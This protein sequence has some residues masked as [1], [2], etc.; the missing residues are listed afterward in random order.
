[1]VSSESFWVFP[2]DAVTTK[3]TSSF[4][5]KKEMLCGKKKS[6]VKNAQMLCI[7]VNICFGWQHFFC[8]IKCQC[9]HAYCSMKEICV[10]VAPTV[11]ALT[12]SSKQSK[13]RQ[14]DWAQQPVRLLIK[15]KK[16]PFRTQEQQN[17]KPL[18]FLS[19]SSLSFL[20]ISPSLALPFCPASVTYWDC[21]W[22]RRRS[23]KM[24]EGTCDRWCSEC[25][26][27][28]TKRRRDE[29]QDAWQQ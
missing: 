26:Q 19:P 14:D 10:C 6:A 27:E 16:L 1:M 23:K 11:R 28:T 21:H 24:R 17:I 2:A 25:F 22:R 29:W 4:S 7:F 15:E 18:L 9:V 13:K 20:K 8:W 12:P 3:A 5:E